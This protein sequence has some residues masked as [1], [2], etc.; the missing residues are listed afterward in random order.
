MKSERGLTPKQEMFVREYLVDL[1]GTQAAIRA[2]YS[3]KTAGQIA[4]RLLR[5]GE[6]QVAVRQETDK[7]QVRTEIT[8][9]RVLSE[10]AAIGFADTTQAIYI[11]NGQVR[12]RDTVDLPERLRPA[13]AEIRETTT[14]DGGS[15]SIKFH[16]KRGALELMGKH[17]GIFRDNPGDEAPPVAKVEIEIKDSRKG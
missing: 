10:L 12:V 6:I 3:P 9:D 17:L 8:A 15:L 2:G 7:R 13:I 1:N 11:E 14:K 4:E 5:K 16:D